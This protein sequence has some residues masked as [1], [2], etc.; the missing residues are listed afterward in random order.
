MQKLR[1]FHHFLKDIV[2]L[3]IFQ[4]DMPRA[5]CPNLWNLIFPK[6]K[7]LAKNQHIT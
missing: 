5:F 4:S 7:I 2:D 1:R 6:Y 3:K